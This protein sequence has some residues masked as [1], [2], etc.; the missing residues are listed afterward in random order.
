MFIW[1]CFRPLREKPDLSDPSG[2]FRET[3]PPA[4]IVAANV[5]VNEA[6]NEVE[7]KRKVH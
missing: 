3:V 7:L 2:L 4:A 5:K 6:L 1:K